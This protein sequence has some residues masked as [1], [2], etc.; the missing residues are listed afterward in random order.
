MLLLRPL[1]PPH[2]LV[3]DV[4]QLLVRLLNLKK[5]EIMVDLNILFH[6]ENF[7]RNPALTFG[8]PPPSRPRP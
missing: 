8:A 5:P 7:N 3:L 1:V 2:P 4:G 6:L